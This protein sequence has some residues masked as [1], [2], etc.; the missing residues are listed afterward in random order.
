MKYQ[1]VKSLTNR[2]FQGVP[3]IVGLSSDGME[4]LGLLVELSSRIFG[5]LRPCLSHQAC[6]CRFHLMD[7]LLSKPV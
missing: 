5:A 2:I 1:S 6:A 3:E 7:F 4:V